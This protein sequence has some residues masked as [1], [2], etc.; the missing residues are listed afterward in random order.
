MASGSSGSFPAPAQMRLVTAD[1]VESRHAADPALSGSRQGE[2]SAYAFCS[3]DCKCEATPR[4]A[5]M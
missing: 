2:A 4:A 3:E 5:R 1:E